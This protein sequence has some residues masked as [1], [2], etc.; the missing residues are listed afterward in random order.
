MSL[1]GGRLNVT[2]VHQSGIFSDA[3][4]GGLYAVIDQ[5]ST[6]PDATPFDPSLTC[7]L[8]LGP[9]PFVSFY[10]NVP[11]RP[12]SDKRAIRVG[13]KWLRLFR[14]RIP[15]WNSRQL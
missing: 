1:R 13:C 3:G 4:G 5:T 6:T 15:V 10:S 7:C 8:E 12:K 2:H 11:S 9:G 14:P